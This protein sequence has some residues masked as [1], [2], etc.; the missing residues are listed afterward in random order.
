MI[1]L[2]REK[3]TNLLVENIELFSDFPAVTNYCNIR[4]LPIGAEGFVRLVSEIENSKELHDLIAKTISSD[5][6]IDKEN[7]DILNGFQ[8]ASLVR[9]NN[10][11]ISEGEETW[12]KNLERIE[13]AL[14]SSCCSTRHALMTEASACY[15]D[16]INQS[17]SE[18]IFVKNLKQ[19]LSVNSITFR[20]PDNTNKQV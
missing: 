7:F 6:E 4:E 20:L 18:W 8:L 16:L 17:S 5:F 12:I 10:I 15:A 19:F 13:E 3:L 2:D 1:K 9:S 11:E 14:K